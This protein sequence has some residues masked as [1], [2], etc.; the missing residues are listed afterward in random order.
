MIN[1]KKINRICAAFST[2][3]LLLCAC[4]NFS[5][6]EDKIKNQYDIYLKNNEGFIFNGQENVEE[7]ENYYFS[8]YVLEEYNQSNYS[9][10]VNGEVVE[11]NNDLYTIN[12]VDKDLY[13]YVYGLV[14]NPS[15]YL[16]VTSFSF[17]LDEYQS[18]YGQKQY[19]LNGV[20]GT[21]QGKSAAVEVNLDEVNFSYPGIY[22]ITYYL[23]YHPEINKKVSLAI[24]DTPKQMDDVEIDVGNIYSAEVIKYET[25][26]EPHLEYEL[27]DEGTLLTHEDVSYN[28][29]KKGNYFTKEYLKSASKGIHNFTAKFSKNISFDFK[30]NIIDELEPQI[31]YTVEKEEFTYTN[32][33]VVSIPSVSLS[34]YSAQDIEFVYYLN[35]NEIN[36]SNISIS[37]I[38][39]YQIKISIKKDGTL[40]P[41]YDKTFLIH[42]RDSYIPFIFGSSGGGSANKGYNDSG[43]QIFNFNYPS[44]DTNLLMDSEY[45]KNYN[46]DNSTHVLLTLKTISVL[47][48][49]SPSLWFKKSVIADGNYFGVSLSKTIGKTYKFIVP[50]VGDDTN[51]NLDPVIFRNCVG[52]FEIKDYHFMDDEEFATYESDGL[53]YLD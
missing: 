49:K 30:V 20:Y 26:G 4:N 12:D 18:E 6:S 51:M 25:Y 16:P 19:Y 22:G 33:E 23:V 53:I 34:D 44:G 42:V 31:I 52:Q 48:S 35:G 39:D 27:Y 28:S 7:G 2:S 38:G 14:K 50:L 15:I 43:N 36:Y 47:E 41:S 1:R 9:V 8:I 37:D 24:L 5:S 21:Y 29:V 10:Y 46:T 32:D 3:I 45:I 40:I 13:I 17:Y 11:G